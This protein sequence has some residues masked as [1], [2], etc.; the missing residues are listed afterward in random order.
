MQRITELTSCLH[1]PHSISVCLHC[2]PHELAQQA[3]QR[4][5]QLS[6]RSSMM[7]PIV[8]GGDG[9]A[10]LALSCAIYIP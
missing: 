2:R 4:I 9:S 1:R 10:V 6:R 8:T 5:A 7:G 3:M